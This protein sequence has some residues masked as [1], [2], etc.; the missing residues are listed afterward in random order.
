MQKAVYNIIWADDEVHELMREEL[1]KKYLSDNHINVV[2]AVTTGKEFR[3]KFEELKHQIDAVVTDANFNKNE[4]LPNDDRDMS[5]FT[6]VRQVF[7]TISSSER[8]I[9]FFLYTGRGQFIVEK[10]TDGELD[11]FIETDRIFTKDKFKQLCERIPKDV[12]A[13]NSPSYRIR[14][15]YKEALDK[16][17][18][19][20]DNEKTLFRLMLAHEGGCKQDLHKAQDD[21]NSLRKIVESILDDGKIKKIFPMQID[22]LNSFKRYL[23]NEDSSVEWDSFTCP[24]ALAFEVGFLIDVS[25]DGSHKYEG[26]KLKADEYVSKVNNDFIMMS[27]TF[28]AMDFCI[29]YY[30]LLQSF[31]GWPTWKE[32]ERETDRGVVKR[33][34]SKFYYGSAEIQTL[35]EGDEVEVRKIRPHGHPYTIY[36]DI[37]KESKMIDS[38][39]ALGDY[40]IL[41]KKKDKTGQSSK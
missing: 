31:D 29:W 8:E 34:R 12:D 15:K 22:S 38:F 3:L 6:V 37:A 2:A 18:I 26:L 30:N 33:N 4:A 36:D 28:I 35:K 7:H 19:L 5:G 1:K 39:I 11:Y 41:P 16:A 13:I 24:S 14:K 40:K 10:Y 32:R 23:K 27:L 17:S 25:Q 21:F 20:S 9:P